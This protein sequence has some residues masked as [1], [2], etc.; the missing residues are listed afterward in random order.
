[1]MTDEPQ[2]RDLLQR[3]YR[4]ALSLTH[5][6]DE[7]EDLV[8]DAALSISRRGG[9]WTMPFL[10]TIIRNRFIDLY[11]RKKR[12]PFESLDEQTYD[13]YEDDS[14]PEPV[15]HDR[16]EAILGGLKAAEREILYLSAVEEYTTAEIAEMTGRP[17]GTVLSLLH[18]TKL[19]LRKRLSHETGF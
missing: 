10:V 16:M 14:L 1:M 9:P 12:V 3:G 6:P 19:K 13:T 4:Y 5:E 17:R 18:R 11:R 2:L 15:E 8:Q 7:A